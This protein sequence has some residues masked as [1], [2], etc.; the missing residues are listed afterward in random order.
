MRKEG[1]EPSRLTSRDFK[2]RAAAFT[3][4]PQMI[5]TSIGKEGLEPSNPR[6]LAE[7]I[8]QFWY[9][10]ISVDFYILHSEATYPFSLFFSHLGEKEGFDISWTK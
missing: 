5:I 2:S 8:C 4:L 1:F 6:S 10:P 9:I 3:P 7:S